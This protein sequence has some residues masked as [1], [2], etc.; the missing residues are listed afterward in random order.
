MI[1]KSTLKYSKNSKL[2]YN[3]IKHSKYGDL[4]LTLEEKNLVQE[5]L[6]LEDQ[7]FYKQG[8]LHERIIQNAK[9]KKE[10]KEITAL[11]LIYDREGDPEELSYY[12]EQ[13]VK[14]RINILIYKKN[15]NS[16]IP[17]NHY[18]NHSWLF[19]LVQYGDCKLVQK[20]L[21]KHQISDLSQH[22]LEEDLIFESLKKQHNDTTKCLLRYKSRISSDTLEHISENLVNQEIKDC[23][24]QQYEKDALNVK[25][26]DIKRIPKNIKEAL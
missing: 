11:A 7:I 9:R 13:E 19:H 12:M 18:A 17:D 5:A 3:D 6:E 22:S 23:I 4:M 16:N 25:L 21:F 8:I 10:A 2:L 15:Q 20:Y 26:Q 14:K 1:V 24:T